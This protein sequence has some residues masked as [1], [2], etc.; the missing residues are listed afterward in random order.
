MAYELVKAEGVAVLMGT[1]QDAKNYRVKEN[2][3]VVK[4]RQVGGCVMAKV[5]GAV[6][7]YKKPHA[8]TYHRE[9]MRQNGLALYRGL[10]GADSEQLL[11]NMLEY[12]ETLE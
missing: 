9:L 5:A 3:Q 1:V 2:G 10:A 4:L 7:V 12:V 11:D 6:D 8:Q